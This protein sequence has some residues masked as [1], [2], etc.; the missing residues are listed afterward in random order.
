MPQDSWGKILQILLGGKTVVR[1]CVRSW[2]ECERGPPQQRV[3]RV[4]GWERACARTGTTT[5]YCTV[6]CE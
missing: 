3:L 1:A 6:V 2:A 4:Y 5:V